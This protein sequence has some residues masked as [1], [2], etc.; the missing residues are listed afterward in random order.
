[1]PW[2]RIQPKV[3]EISEKV[4]Q[5]SPQPVKEGIDLFQE[6]NLKGLPYETVIMQWL[7]L[8][9]YSLYNLL[10]LKVRIR[11]ALQ[12]LHLQ[13]TYIELKSKFLR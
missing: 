2:K 10:P 11:I 9:T 4:L 13:H 6:A 7:I 8:R 3:R 12:R 1:M 5:M